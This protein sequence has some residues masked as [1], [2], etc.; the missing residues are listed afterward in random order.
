MLVMLAN[1]PNI[2]SQNWQ[3]SFNPEDIWIMRA[4]YP[5][6]VT[7]L[8]TSQSIGNVSPLFLA[9]LPI[10]FFSAVRKKIKLTRPLT[11][12]LIAALITL[13]LWI[14][15]FFTIMEIRYIFF[16]WIILFIASAITIEIALDNSKYAFSKI[17]FFKDIVFP[18]YCCP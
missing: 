14:S 6:V 9:F 16:L 2:S 5:F 10:T 1:T 3:W 13:I 18:C 11:E 15:M 12:M 4:L 8:N 17:L 7:F